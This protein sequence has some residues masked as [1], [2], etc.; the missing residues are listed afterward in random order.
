MPTKMMTTPTKDDNKSCQCCNAKTYHADTPAT[1]NNL[2]STPATNNHATAKLS[3][4][5]QKPTSPMPQ[6]K[7]TP[8]QQNLPC[9]CC[10]NE[11]NL[12]NATAT[13][14]T[15]LMPWQQNQLCQQKTPSQCRSQ[16]NSLAN[17]MAKKA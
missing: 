7:M 6:Q 12:T 2:A 11:T 9:Q 16:K 15:L 8:W 3:P 13:K 17:S 1:K 4:R 10:S 14:P 5:Q